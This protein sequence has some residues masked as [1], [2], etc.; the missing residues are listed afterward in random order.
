M[1]PLYTIAEIVGATGGEAR[2]IVA[3]AVTSIS[4]DSREI[5]SGALFVAIKGENFDGHDF[6]AKAVEAGAVAALV[7]ADK[8]H[9]LDGLPLIVVPDALEG[10]RGLAR[11][12]R[13]RTRARIVAVTGSVGKTSVKEAIR[14]IFSAHG[15]THASI[16]SFNNHWGVPLTLARMPA[17]TAYGVFEIGMS[18]AG[19]ITPLSQLVRPHT[20]LI[21]TVAP[22]HLEFFDSE[23]GIAVAKAEILAGLE[24]GGR[25]ILGAD[26]AH[27]GR[28]LAHAKA[29]GADALT[30]GF[31]AGAR[32]RISGYRTEDGGGKASV[33]G[34]GLDIELSVS[35]P[36]RHT[37]VNGVGALLAAREVGVPV[38][39][40]LDVLATHGAPEGRGLAHRLGGGPKPLVLIDESYN[41][42]PASMG[43]ALDVFA[44]MTVPSGQRVLVLG[45]MRELGA[46]A[47]ALHAALAP[48]V[49]AASPD[50]VWLVGEH[51]AALG[52]ALPE[53]LV[54]GRA[55]E[56]A[57]IAP[58]LAGALAYGDLVM[59][60]GS[61]GLRLGALV[62]HL[63][64]Q[65]GH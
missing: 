34:D 17:E 14:A 32:V 12:S 51:M 24:P 5:A 60:K 9:R 19:E 22:A 16:K 15:P 52:A 47:D 48:A 58:A 65:F 42:N 27:I 46:A 4:I 21:T 36:G 56:A 30:Y 62:A 20:A 53:G 2:G 63:R 29:R 44:Q 64:S 43:A 41:A 49:L 3:E 28:L 40:A 11:F 39:V 6:V 35:T 33:S 10:L 26:H 61:N 31:D 1:N 57:E 23:A 7:S 45:D 50:A 54:V 37:L 38:D 55:T 59:V 8:T 13:T 25:I 18:A